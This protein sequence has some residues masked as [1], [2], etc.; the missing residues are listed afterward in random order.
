MNINNFIDCES[1]NYLIVSPFYDA[2]ANLEKAFSTQ[3]ERLNFDSNLNEY[4]SRGLELI[5]RVQHL[6]AGILLFLPLVNLIA[7][8]ALFYFATQ[9]VPIPHENLLQ[10]QGHIGAGVLPYCAIEGNLYFLLSKEGFG[11]AKDTWC[12]FGG[13]KNPGETVLRT[14]AREC[15]E[16]SRGILGSEEEIRH[17]IAL[18]SPIGLLSY[19]MFLM[20]VENPVE[21][22]NGTFISIQ[23]DDECRMEKAEI[24]WVNAEEVFTAATPHTEQIM[25]NHTPQKLRDCFKR[26]IQSTIQDGT[27]A[28]AKMDALFHNATLLTQETA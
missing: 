23:H 4:E 12:D 1:S 11:H 6:A 2:Y 5:D 3:S 28:K 8:Y 18:D 27:P 10:R 7:Y 21:I 20:K 16:E 24:A 13:S 15:Y 26:A 25:I 14:A 19:P 22:D 9:H 17:R